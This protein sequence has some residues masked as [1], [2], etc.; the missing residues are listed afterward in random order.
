MPLSIPP[1]PAMSNERSQYDLS[2]A[3]QEAIEGLKLHIR[4]LEAALTRAKKALAALISEVTVGP[5]SGMRP[6]A[7]VKD[8]LR[9]KGTWQS[10]ESVVKELLAMGCGSRTAHPAVNIAKGINA[11]VRCKTVVKISGKAEEPLLGLPEWGTPEDEAVEKT[12]S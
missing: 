6:Q 2:Q 10:Y 8:Y 1:S 4:E 11:C 5:Y 12:Q 9:R 7:A 3:Q